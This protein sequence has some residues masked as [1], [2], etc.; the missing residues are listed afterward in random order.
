MA[1][2]P[3][4]STA[5]LGALV[6]ATVAAI[7]WPTLRPGARSEIPCPPEIGLDTRLAATLLW[8]A[9]ENPLLAAAS[10]A[11]GLLPEDLRLLAEADF[12]A[13]GRI[14]A[15]IPDSLQPLGLYAPFHAAF[16]EVGGLYVAPVLPRVTPGEMSAEV[17]EGKRIDK[18]GVTFVFDPEFRL[19]AAL[20]N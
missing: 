12:A 15:A 1:R 5:L 9:P 19:L 6:A 16:Y 3:A 13:C 4:R 8:E 14:L 10:P 17:F 18:K 20:E 2:Y 7:A 11:R